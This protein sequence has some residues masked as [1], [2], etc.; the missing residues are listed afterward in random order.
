MIWFNSGFRGIMFNDERNVNG[1]KRPRRIAQVNFCTFSR[2]VSANN[3][4]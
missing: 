3:T 2:C 1:Q 4:G